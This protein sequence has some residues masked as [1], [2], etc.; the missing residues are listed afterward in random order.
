VNHTK[1]KKPLKN[2]NILKNK[3][4]NCISIHIN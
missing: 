3:T 2:S 1:K 4:L